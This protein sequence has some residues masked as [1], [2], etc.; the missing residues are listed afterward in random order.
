MGKQEYEI[1]MFHK[2]A[3]VEGSG[4]ILSDKD[5]IKKFYEF[6]MACGYTFSSKKVIKIIL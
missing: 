4:I 3:M 6:A 5:K 1:I 2:D